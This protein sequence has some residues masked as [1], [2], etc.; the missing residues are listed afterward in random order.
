MLPRQRMPTKAG[1]RNIMTPAVHSVLTH[2]YTALYPISYNTLQCIVWRRQ[3]L[4]APFVPKRM[5]AIVE[6][7]V[8]MMIDDSEICIKLI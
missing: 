8:V 4:E 2:R 6:A 7:I 3:C 1:N 5:R